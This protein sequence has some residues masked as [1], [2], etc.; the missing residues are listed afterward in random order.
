M[1]AGVLRQHKPHIYQET[2]G[3]RTPIE[4]GYI[5]RG[6]QQIG[7]VVGTY[8][9]DRPLIIDPVLDYSTYLGSAGNETPTGVAVDTNGNV[10]LSGATSSNN[11][12]AA[13]GSF[14]PVFNGFVDAFVTKL[15]ST[16]STILYLTY[17]GGTGDDQASDL[18]VDSAGNVYLTGFTSSLNFPTLTPVQAANG[19]VYDAFVAKLDP[20]GAAL[21]Y[22]TYLGGSGYETI[23]SGGGIALDSTGNAYVT[24]STFS[25]NFPTVNALQP[26]LRGSED[27]FVAKL[28]AGGSAL[29]FSTYLG[30]D[31]N[32]KSSDL[33]VDTAG[34]VYVAGATFSSNFPTANAFQSAFGGGDR[35]AFVTKLN[36]QG[37]AI[38]YSTFLGGGSRDE[39][40]DIA[41]DLSGNAIVIGETQSTN[42]PTVNPLQPTFGGFFDVF[43]TRLGGT[44]ATLLYSTYLGSSGDDRGLT[45]AVDST[46]MVYLG[47]QTDS[48]NFPVTGDAY[49]ALHALGGTDAFVAKL[50]PATSTLAYSTFLGGSGSDQVNS[51]AVDSA[52]NAYV[53][54]V[55][56]SPDFPRTRPVQA[57]YGGAD[58][59][60]VA[61]IV[62]AAAST[63]DPALS[64]T[65]SPSPVVQGSNLTYTLTVNN[66]GP[67]DAVNVVVRDTLPNVFGTL[68]SV[69]SSQGTCTGTSCSLGTVTGGGSATM[70][71][72]VTPTIIGQ[73]LNQ[74]SV[75]SDLPDPDVTNNNASISLTVQAA[76]APPSADLRITKTDSPDPLIV[77]S[78]LTY[79]ITV[80]NLGPEAASDVAVTDDLPASVTFQSATP[81][82][83]TCS[84]ANSLTCA[85]GTITAGANATVSVVVTPTMVGTLS[86][87]A[88]VTTSA[89]D[90]VSTNNSALQ[91]SLV[92]ADPASGPWADL[93]VSVSDSPDPVPVTDALTYTVTVT[94]DGPSSADVTLTDSVSG[95]A[96]GRCSGISFLLRQVRAPATRN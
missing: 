47:G 31:G 72:V 57:A 68:V 44:G 20:S 42:F 94:N 95:E 18:A 11:F 74:A 65:A 76:P 91:T 23:F 60:F 2:Q 58:E 25:L 46:G 41:V 89:L 7:F 88:Q 70:T 69:A 17:L 30:G 81:S 45:L 15:N 78:N 28:N 62:E 1:P 51:L 43:V 96:G 85:L 29:V 37:S 48:T 82:Q 40:F 73:L 90:P 8:D 26:T 19:G 66:L 10:Y 21:V 14:S 92:N 33:A 79:T 87:T 12:L 27:A 3:G 6:P 5:L 83:G 34:N 36:A 84:G 50:N 52:G 38:V 86:N 39:A 77:G 32:D 75:Y 54:G 61:K 4:G 56:R 80:T 71:I 59:V 13:V 22:S 53:V 16:G 67:N 24:G 93:R 55:T 35:D 49:Q 9:R 63:A 64:M